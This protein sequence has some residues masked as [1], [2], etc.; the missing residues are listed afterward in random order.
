MFGKVEPWHWRLA[1]LCLVGTFALVTPA[2]RQVTP[3]R[4]ILP[5]A[6]RPWLHTWQMYSGWGRG[7]CDAHYRARVNGTWRDVDQVRLLE[8]KSWLE[9]TPGKRRTYSVE[10]ETFGAA[11]CRKLGAEDVR[12][13]AACGTRRGWRPASDPTK[14]LCEKP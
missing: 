14:N 12:L 9:L 8:G 2:F 4:G 6:V 10:L 3:L 7:T 5:R 13:D 1:V 11:I